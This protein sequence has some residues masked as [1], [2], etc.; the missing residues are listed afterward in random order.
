MVTRHSVKSDEEKCD[1]CG[2]CVQACAEGAL[3]I[4]GGKARLVKESYCDGLGACLGE[5]PMG[6]I[7]IEQREAESSPSLLSHWPVKLK[8]V[9]AKAPYFRY[10]EMVVAADCGP[11][12]YGSFHRDF[13]GEK[14]LVIGCPKFDDLAYY[15]EKLTEI[16]RNSGIKKLVV[17]RMEVPC[18]SAL[19]TVVQNAVAASGKEITIEQR[20]IGITGELITSRGEAEGDQ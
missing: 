19:L 8:L 20:V 17:A 10:E 7:T 5:C 11:F 2:I 16:L 18:C 12:A 1:G 9:S 15:Q 14:A 4:V 3:Q 13:L 6:A